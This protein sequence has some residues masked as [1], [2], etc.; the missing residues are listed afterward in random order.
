MH[1]VN[2]FVLDKMEISA[3]KELPPGSTTGLSIAAVERDTGLGKDTLRVW[4][5][6]YGFPVPHRDAH[7]ERL[8][9]AEQ[10]ERLRRIKRLMDLGMRP[11]KIFAS[12]DE[13]WDAWLQKAP[14]VAQIE[15]PPGFIELVR[16]HRSEEL[17]AS[18]QQSLLKQGLERFVIDTVAPMNVAVGDAWMRGALDV[19]EEHLYTEQVQ[20]LL[21]SAISQRGEARRPPR[22]LLTT[23]PEEQHSLGLLMVESLLVSESAQCVSLGTGTP[24]ADVQNA[25]LSGDFDI[26]ALSFSAVF[27]QRHAA[28]SLQTLSAQLAGRCEIWAGGRGI[29]SRMPK[30]PNVHY[31]GEISTVLDA[32]HDWRN[33]KL[34]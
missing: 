15:T 18:L 21:R 22:V 29:S 3:S 12:T 5:R 7:G 11:G 14:P 20:N 32:L 16:M 23:L 1:K 8:Y 27:P 9:P 28:E 30:L 25:A 6:R 24:L 34:A 19:T 4:E 31:L 33:R 17:R 13:E 2:K 10:V 26:L